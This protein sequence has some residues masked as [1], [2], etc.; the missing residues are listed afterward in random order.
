MPMP[1]RFA[2]NTPPQNWAA[3]Q[4]QQ[5]WQQY[6]QSGYPP[7]QPYGYAP[8]KRSGGLKWL[9]AG[10]AGLVVVA[11]VVVTLVLVNR[12]SGTSPAP[13]TAPNIPVGPSGG[14]TAQSTGGGPPPATISIRPSS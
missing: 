11:A 8:P 12:D 14:S 13:T 7:Q 6:Q 5:G 4:Q 10:I 3:Q 2:P 1:P 9:W